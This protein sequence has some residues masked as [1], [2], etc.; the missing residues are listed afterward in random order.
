[1]GAED[2]Y[3]VVIAKYG[4][5][6]TR[7]SEVFLNFHL[8]GE[9]D[10]PMQMDYFLWVV[11][12][13]A[14]D[15]LVDTGFSPEGG[16]TRG[17]TS[18]TNIGDMLDQIGVNRAEP[19]PIVVTHAHYDHIGNLGLFPRSEI[20]MSERELAFWTGPNG[21]QP[22]FHHSVDDQGIAYLAQ[23][24][25][26]G[27]L[28]LFRDELR[29]APGVTVTEVGGH[30]PGQ[31]VVRVETSDGAVLLAS[32]AVHYYEELD[33][34]MPFSSVADLVKMYDAFHAIKEMKASGAIDHVVAGHDP[35]TLARFKPLPGPYQDL[36]STIGEGP[37][38][39]GP[40]GPA[41]TVAL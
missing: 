16:T 5:R 11:R 8:Y 25:Q 34:E 39:Q 7:R 13:K 3:Q 10:A 38:R 12:G 30:T 33:R 26:E 21:R 24:G 17:R 1:M 6:T 27:R 32:D 14:Q 40:S 4:T 18:L 23:A 9:P 37:L 19:P 35:G 20:Y 22:L 41:G 28:H 36:A 15:I 2:Q 29:L 31:C